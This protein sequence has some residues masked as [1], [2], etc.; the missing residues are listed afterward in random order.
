[1]KKN[2]PNLEKEVKFKIHS[3]TSPEQLHSFV[4]SLGM[5]LHRKDV[6][7]DVYW[8][9]A[10]CRIINLKRGLRL[11]YVKGQLR[12]VE[13]KSLFQNQDGKY[14]VEEIKLYERG[15]CDYDKLRHILVD[16]LQIMNS[17]VFNTCPSTGSPEQFLSGIVLCPAVIIDKERNVYRD[18]EQQI[19]VCIDTIPELGTFVEVES[20]MTSDTQFNGIVDKFTHSGFATADLVHAGYLDLLIEKDSKI[21]SPSQFAEQFKINPKWN[22]QPNEE[23]LYLALIGSLK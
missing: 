8:D 3:E 17:D 5:T 2:P 15:V 9:T 22:V 19:E 21:S 23:S 12:H 13:F 7:R 4:T 16:R 20:L 11:R 14:V 6:Q 1:M 10:D 18:Q